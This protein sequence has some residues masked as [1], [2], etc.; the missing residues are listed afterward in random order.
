MAAV[1]VYLEHGFEHDRV[2]VSAGSAEHTEADVTTRY[3]VGLARVVEVE[4]PT[5]GPSVVRVAVPERHLAAEAQVDPLATPHVRVSITGESLD[6]RPQAA[7][8]M[9]A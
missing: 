4:V 7:P 1:H 6:V 3:Q 8:P 9:F 2:T 5:A